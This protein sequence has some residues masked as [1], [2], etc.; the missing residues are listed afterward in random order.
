[1]EIIDELETYARNI[2]TGMIFTGND[3]HFDSS[4]VI[5]T[6]IAKD[7]RLYFNVGGAV[8][9]DSIPEKEYEETLAKAQCIIKALL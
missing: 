2:Y 1:M 9:Y 6:I 7:G 8:V 5:R 4:V 3:R